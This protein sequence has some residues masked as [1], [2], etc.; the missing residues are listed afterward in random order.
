MCIQDRKEQFDLYLTL[1]LEEMG[2]LNEHLIIQ[3]K[4]SS[5]EQ[6]VV[7]QM[8][9]RHIGHSYLTVEFGGKLLALF[10][11]RCLEIPSVKVVQLHLKQ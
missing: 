9:L 3:S 5:L 10:Q 2:S 4:I 1:G 8:G 7:P 11:T 6:M